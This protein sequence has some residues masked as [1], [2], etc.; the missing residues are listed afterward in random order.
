MKDPLDVALHAIPTMLVCAGMGFM[1]A[2]ALH[3]LTDTFRVLLALGALAGGL[4]FCAMWRVREYDQHGGRLGGTQSW[5]EAY[6]PAIVGAV[7]LAVTTPVF[8]F[9]AI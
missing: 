3:D 5:L 7:T 4:G 9:L 8:Y 1:L 6:V 2:F